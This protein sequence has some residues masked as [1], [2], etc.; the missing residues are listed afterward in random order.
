MSILGRK[1]DVSCIIPTGVRPL[2]VQ[3]AIEYW[4][5][6]SMSKTCRE[7]IIATDGDVLPDMSGTAGYNITLVEVKPGP[8]KDS[9]VRNMSDGIRYASGEYIAVWEDDDWYGIDRLERQYKCII[10]TGV[11]MV[12][13][14]RNIYYNIFKNM[15]RTMLTPDHAS[16]CAMMYH[17]RVL[18]Y[19][20]Y[21]AQP[22]GVYCDLEM[23]KRAKAH[24]GLYLMDNHTCRFV[25]GIK[26]ATGYG[27]GHRPEHPRW[28][29]DPG[30][31][32]LRDIIGEEDAEWYANNLDELKRTTER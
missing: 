17:R 13:A 16:H 26:H 10:E 6:Q 30:W 1:I 9:M 22:K 31:R 25:T 24:G 15:F 23:S 7:L 14:D 29:K 27:I 11:D 20:D 2:F 12:G 28:N 5:R 4:K 21:S 32:Y 18:R 19:F 8:K 3:R